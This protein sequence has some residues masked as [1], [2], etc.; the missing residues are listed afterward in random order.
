[1]PNFNSRPVSTLEAIAVAAALYKQ[2]NNQVILDRNTLGVP[3][4]KTCLINHFDQKNVIENLDYEEAESIQK[5]IEHEIV[6]SAL[7]TN[8]LPEFIVN[9]SGIISKPTTTLRL[10]A[11]IGWAPALAASINRKNNE[12]ETLG[13]F[14]FSSK[15]FG[16]YHEKVNLTVTIIEQN[17]LKHFQTYRCTCYTDSDN[18]VKFYTKKKFSDTVNVTAKIKNHVENNGIKVTVL[19]YVKEIK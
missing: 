10:M 7:R 1:M 13:K 17:Y 2:N 4:T 11:Y 5:I 18:I 6:V 14:Q 16:K 19:N 3:S 15:H 8:P 12:K 9:V